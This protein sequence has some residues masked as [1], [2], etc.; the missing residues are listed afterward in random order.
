MLGMVLLGDYV[1]LY[2]AILNR[3]DPTGVA[4]ID[5]LKSRLSQS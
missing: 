4:Q 1:S 3:V 2:L 5:Y